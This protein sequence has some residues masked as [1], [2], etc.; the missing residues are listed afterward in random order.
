MPANITI[1]GVLLEPAPS[2]GT[3]FDGSFASSSWDG[4]AVADLSP[5]TYRSLVGDTVFGSSVPSRLDSNDGT[6]YTMGTYF[7]PSVDATSL[8]VHWRAPTTPIGPAVAQWQVWNIDTSTLI[9]SGT[10]PYIAWG[11]WNE[12]A[13]TSLNF[14]AGVQYCISIVTNRYCATTH[15]FDSDVTHGIITGPASAG[16]FTDIGVSTVAVRPTSAFLNGGYFVDMEIQAGSP[17]AGPQAYVWDGATE[18]PASVFVWNGSSE[19]P[20][21]LELAP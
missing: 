19:V 5:S 17:P 2:L 20:A 15:F 7:R 6:N 10:F 3:Y 14:V 16:R 12:L 13:L 21:T 8:A 1:T 9:T 4:S 11:A 18:H